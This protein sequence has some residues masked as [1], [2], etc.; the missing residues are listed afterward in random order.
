MFAFAGT[1]FT[2]QP[3]RTKN[4]SP[5]TNDVGKATPLASPLRK[6]IW[7]RQCHVHA[8]VANKLILRVRRIQGTNI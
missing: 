3:E 1:Y 8:T 7:R 5:T 2:S 6:K 4:C